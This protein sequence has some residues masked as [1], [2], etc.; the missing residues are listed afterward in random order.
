MGG[1]TTRTQRVV[2]KKQGSSGKGLAMGHQEGIAQNRRGRAPITRVLHSRLWQQG[3]D[4]Q[5]S[6]PPTQR[7]AKNHL[8]WGCR[9]GVTPAPPATSPSHPLP[10]R[11]TQALISEGFLFMSLYGR[12]NVNDFQHKHVFLLLLP[13][14]GIFLLHPRLS[15][16]LWPGSPLICQCF[17]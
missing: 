4:V 2:D 13:D 6:Q 16:V 8:C 3:E 9:R 14:L 17:Y 10:A 1:L 7:S 15:A 12:V 11:P 5:G